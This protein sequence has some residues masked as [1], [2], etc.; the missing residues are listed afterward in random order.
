MEQYVN[1]ASFCVQKAEHERE[2][3]DYHRADTALFTAEDRQYSASVDLFFIGMKL[4]FD[5][6]IC[7]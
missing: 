7:L 2:H 1:H 5:E 3:S 4:I 6:N